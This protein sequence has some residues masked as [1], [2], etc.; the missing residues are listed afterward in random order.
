MFMSWI[1]NGEEMASGERKTLKDFGFLAGAL[2]VSIFGLLM[3]VLKSRPFELW[4]WVVAVI[5]WIPAL[6]FPFALGPVYFLW[7]KIGLVLGW[8]NTRIILTV[9]FFLIFF[10]AAIVMRILSRDLLNRKFKP[11]AKT[12]AKTRKPIEPKKMEVPF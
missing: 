2:F 5:L 10:P 8:V 12:Y 1:N 7:M 3:P 9:I 4:P 6:F 11:E